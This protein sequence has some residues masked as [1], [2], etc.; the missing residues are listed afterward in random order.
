MLYFYSILVNVYLLDENYFDFAMSDK[1]PLLLY[2]IYNEGDF[3]YSLVIGK[4]RQRKAL[5]TFENGR[6][7][8]RW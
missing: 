5:L 7:V 1:H 4:Q 6:S 3:L 8:E 2:M